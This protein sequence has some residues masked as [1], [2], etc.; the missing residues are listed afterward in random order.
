MPCALFRM[1]NYTGR[2]KLSNM[3]LTEI[4]AESDIQ[5]GAILPDGKIVPGAVYMV[6]STARAAQH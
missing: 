1:V 2:L 4:T 6:K 5:R 3:S